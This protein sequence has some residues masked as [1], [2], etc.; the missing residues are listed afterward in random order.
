MER[1]ER[2]MSGKI[3]NSGHGKIGISLLRGKRKTHPLNAIS[4][5]PC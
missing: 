4:S 2:V 5:L 3:E 1:V